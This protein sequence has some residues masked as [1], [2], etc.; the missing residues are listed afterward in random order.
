LSRGFYLPWQ[1][2]TMIVTTCQ[3]HKKF[4]TTNGTLITL[5]W[6]I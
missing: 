5:S 4:P 1:S 6:M 3:S 2:L